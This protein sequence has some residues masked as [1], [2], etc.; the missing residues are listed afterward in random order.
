MGR[1]RMIA[2]NPSDDVACGKPERSHTYGHNERIPMSLHHNQ[3]SLQSPAPSYNQ[4][5][6]T[7]KASSLGTRPI[8]NRVLLF[9]PYNYPLFYQ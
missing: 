7:I 6:H 4:K 9:S 8:F 5:S 3:P 1:N 2:A